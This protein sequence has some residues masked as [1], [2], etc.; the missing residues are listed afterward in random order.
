[1][2]EIKLFDHL[3]IPGMWVRAGFISFWLVNGIIDCC[4]HVPA[5]ADRS[6]KQQEMVNSF[7][8]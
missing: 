1:L 7:G 3:L 4:I 6:T 2:E 5:E 8:F